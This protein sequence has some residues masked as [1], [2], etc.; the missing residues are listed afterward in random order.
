M[1]V[2]T[3]YRTFFLPEWGGSVLKKRVAFSEGEVWGLGGAR[4]A[5]SVPKGH[6][7]ALLAAPKS[8]SVTVRCFAG[9]PAVLLL[10]NR[11]EFEIRRMSEFG[12]FEK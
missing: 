10:K 1:S 5:A 4:Q 7:E 9:F 6:T 2:K 11:K 3:A 8:T 12:N